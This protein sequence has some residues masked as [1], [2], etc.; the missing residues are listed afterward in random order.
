[1]DKTWTENLWRYGTSTPDLD[2]DPYSRLK[3]KGLLLPQ[4]FL[5]LQTTYIILS[6]KMATSV[7][8]KV[9]RAFDGVGTPRLFSA[10]TAVSEI[11]LL[12]V[13]MSS[14]K[15]MRVIGFNASMH[16]I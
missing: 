5:L 1:M 8:P 6:S 15:N 3:R 13:L 7:L 10:S 12:R 2:V 14:Y 11:Q 4:R 16:I 9:A